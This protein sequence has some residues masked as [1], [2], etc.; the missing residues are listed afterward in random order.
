VYLQGKALR[1]QLDLRRYGPRWGPTRAAG[2]V[3]SA[4]AH[5]CFPSLQVSHLFQAVSTGVTGGE[6]TLCQ[7]GAWEGSTALSS[8]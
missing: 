6:Q 1:V 7:P 5:S 8:S 3:P 4:P 2:T